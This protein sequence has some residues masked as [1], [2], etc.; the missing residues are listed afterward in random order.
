MAVARTAGAL[1]ALYAELATGLASGWAQ[2]GAG[3][4]SNGGLESVT[5]G[6]TAGGFGLAMG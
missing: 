6:E 4:A 1:V 3:T 2:D 5:T